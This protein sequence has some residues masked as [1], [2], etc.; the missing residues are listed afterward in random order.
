MEFG[1]EF[2]DRNGS[3]HDIRLTLGGAL[4]KGL[5]LRNNSVHTFVTGTNPTNFKAIGIKFK[6]KDINISGV[7]D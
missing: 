4:T 3:Q 7:N 5:S 2:F 1:R 6:W